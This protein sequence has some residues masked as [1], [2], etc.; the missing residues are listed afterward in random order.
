MTSFVVVVVDVAVAILSFLSAP[1]IISFL[2]NPSSQKARNNTLQFPLTL[3]IRLNSVNKFIMDKVYSNVQSLLNTP[4]EST[5]A[6]SQI[7]KS[8]VIIRNQLNTIRQ[9]KEKNEKI[10]KSYGKLIGY[11][12]DNAKHLNDVQ[13]FAE[14]MDQEL[15]ILEGTFQ[16]LDRNKEYNS[17]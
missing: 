12:L 4:N 13:R 16:I 10:C 1:K 5:H 9:S 3:T 17:K 7:R 2:D 11:T 6:L 14:K 8:D 15:R